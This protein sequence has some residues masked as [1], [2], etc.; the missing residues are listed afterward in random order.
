MFDGQGKVKVIDF[1]LS[2]S[3]PPDVNGTEQMLVT[4][5]G[6]PAYAAPELLNVKLFIKFVCYT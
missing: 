5:C 3:L 1:G 4:Q 2:N 6:S